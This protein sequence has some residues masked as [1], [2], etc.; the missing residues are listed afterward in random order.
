MYLSNL[1][2]FRLKYAMFLKSNGAIFLVH[3]QLCSETKKMPIFTKSQHWL[4]NTYILCLV[5]ERPIF[6][7]SVSFRI[8]VIGIPQSN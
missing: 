2:T 4:R 1:T 8:K 3:E 6:N 5:E 7:I